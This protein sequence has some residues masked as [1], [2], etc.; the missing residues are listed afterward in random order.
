MKNTTAHLNL[1]RKKTQAGAT[2]PSDILAEIK[3]IILAEEIKGKHRKLQH[4]NG[5]TPRAVAMQTLAI[6][7]EQ[8]QIKEH[9]KRGNHKQH[10][11]LLR[12]EHHLASMI[13][14]K[15]NNQFGY[16]APFLNAQGVPTSNQLSLP[17]E[18]GMLG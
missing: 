15:E 9:F 12:D 10:K 11:A 8:K 18:G 17:Y 13:G 4:Q 16:V 7:K 14:S 6:Q 3:S 5:N 2:T 1:E